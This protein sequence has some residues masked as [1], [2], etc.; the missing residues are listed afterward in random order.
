MENKNDPGVQDKLKKTKS[1]KIIVS[2][3]TKTEE[4]SIK[5]RC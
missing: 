4:N 1:V 5:V 3:L 2:D